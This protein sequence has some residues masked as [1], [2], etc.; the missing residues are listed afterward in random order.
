[1]LSLYTDWVVWQ[2]FAVA[3]LLGVLLVIVDN[4]IL[5]VIPTLLGWNSQW[6]SYDRNTDGSH[7]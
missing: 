5:Q 7:G 4:V 3:A 2:F 1:M 6:V